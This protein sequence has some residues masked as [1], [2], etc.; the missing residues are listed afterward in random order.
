MAYFAVPLLF[1]TLVHAENVQGP[2]EFMK[3]GGPEEKFEN[4]MKHY[5]PSSCLN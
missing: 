5:W 3:V 1:I 2:L 4:P